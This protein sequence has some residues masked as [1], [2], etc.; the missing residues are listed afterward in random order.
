M[1]RVGGTVRRGSA[2]EAADL[3][4]DA[5][6][7]ERAIGSGDRNGGSD[8]G[9]VLSCAPRAPVH[10]H[11]GVVAE[12]MAFDLRAALACAARSRGAGTSVDERIADLRERLAGGTMP[13]I[14]LADARRRVASA[15]GEEEALRE[16]VAALRGRVAARREVG[17]DPEAAAER[18]RTATGRLAEV[19]TERVA[20]EQALAAARRACRENRDERERRLRLADRLA[21]A[22]RE[23]RRALA[24]D[25]ADGFVE[26]VAAVPGGPAGG[27]RPEEFEGDPV[28]AALAVARLAAVESPIVLDCRRF[29]SAAA[30]RAC[31]D[32]P[33]IRL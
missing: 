9:V 28:T 10:E 14:D 13:E 16:Q 2:I 15:S 5:A 25:L 7:I 32:A 29:E 4:V 3:A 33:V 11:V 26:S 6:A 1:L 30:A 12:G 20:A 23:A 18:L 22:E 24:R 21:N 19:E 8:G 27:S 17:E 31:L